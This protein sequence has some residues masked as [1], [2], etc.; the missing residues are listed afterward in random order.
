MK[1]YVTEAIVLDREVAGETD[2]RVFLYTKELG[3]VLARAKSAE[4]MTS[5]LSA[6]LQPL[7]R[8]TARLVEKNGVQIVDAL[9]HADKRTVGAE[10]VA[11]CGIVSALTSPHHPDEQLWHELATPKPSA[12][13]ILTILGF[14]PRHAHCHQC[15]GESP[16]YFSVRDAH[17]YCVRCVRGFPSIEGLY[18]LSRIKA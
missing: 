17:Y 3:R 11:V 7:K 10:Q 8:I 9:I 4:L 2:A 18:K 6:H 5:R 15:E 12:L 16:E 1:E 13:K 14:D